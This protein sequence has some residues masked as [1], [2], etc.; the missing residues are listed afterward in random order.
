[1]IKTEKSNKNLVIFDFINLL[2]FGLKYFRD[3]QKEFRFYEFF[4]AQKEIQ[5]F[6]KS[7]KTRDFDN[8]NFVCIYF[9]VNLLFFY[10]E[11]PNLFIAEVQKFVSNSSVFEKINIFLT[12]KQIK[13]AIID[14]IYSLEYFESAET[15]DINKNELENQLIF[16]YKLLIDSQDMFTSQ[17]IENSLETILQS[18][19]WILTYKVL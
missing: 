16:K 4:L 2:L 6:S 13:E 12:S 14:A 10:Y 9:F 8:E 15:K 7:L 19:E 3:R 18:Q 1:M 11:K 5:N 17:N